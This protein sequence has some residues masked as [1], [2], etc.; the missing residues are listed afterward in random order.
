MGRESRGKNVEVGKCR[1]GSG[2]HGVES[3]FREAGPQNLKWLLFP[4]HQIK[5]GKIRLISGTMQ[6]LENHLILSTGLPSAPSLFIA[7]GGAPIGL[8]LGTAGLV[9]DRSLEG[10]QRQVVRILRRQVAAFS[11]GNGHMKGFWAG[12]DIIRLADIL[13][14]WGEGLLK[15]DGE[16]EQGER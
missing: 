7:A 14:R 8:R 6:R 16:E 9:R 5:T 1:V 13:E 12:S 4:L 15:E 10:R 2:P 11:A 3:T